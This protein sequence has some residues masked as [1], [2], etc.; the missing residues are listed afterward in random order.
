MNGQELR[1]KADSFDADMTEFGL[2][3]FSGPALSARSS[4][5]YTPNQK[6]V[7]YSFYGGSTYIAL[8]YGEV[9]RRLGPAIPLTKLSLMEA[10]FHLVLLRQMLQG[11]FTCSETT[12]A[13]E[14]MWDPG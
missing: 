13:K 8:C 10:W 9:Q 6:V 14:N 12:S 5:L 7:L 4:L 3:S 1:Y 11:G 2:S